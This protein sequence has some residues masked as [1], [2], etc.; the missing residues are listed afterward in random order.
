MAKYLLIESRD[1][2]EYGDVSYLCGLAGDLAAA[3]NDVN[4]FLLQNGVLMAR[5]G[6]ES[7]V[8]GLLT[9][10]KVNVLADDFCLKERAIALGSLLSGVK[11]SNVDHLVDMLAEDDIKPVWH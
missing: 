7:P 6:T 2:F 9:G 10:G 4:L 8:Q 1:P 11:V 5:Q 3:G